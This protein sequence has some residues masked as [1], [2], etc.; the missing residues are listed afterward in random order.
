M[1]LKAPKD[2]PGIQFGAEWFSADEHGVVTIP[3][4][5]TL[6]AMNH[7]FMRIKADVVGLEDSIKKTKEK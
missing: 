4:E 7:G 1:R 6:T 5:Y 2:C 3:D